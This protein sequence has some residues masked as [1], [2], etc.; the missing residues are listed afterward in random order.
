VKRGKHYIMAGA[1]IAAAT[2]IV[3]AGTASAHQASVGATCQGGVSVSL[4]NYQAK[5]LNS[6]TITLDGAVVASNPNFGGS[7]SKTVP[8]PDKTTTHTWTVDVTAGDS[9]QYDVHQAGT[10]AACASP[11]TTTTAPPTTTTTRPAP[12]APK[13]PAPA[14]PVLAPAHF[15]G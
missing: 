7:Y 4:I 5:A 11:P 12:P 15:T 2:L 6:V 14:P 8:N 9:A 1:A 3:T 13:P 10:I